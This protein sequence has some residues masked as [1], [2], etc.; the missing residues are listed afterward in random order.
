[1]PCKQNKLRVNAEGR[2]Y[3][4]S[5]RQI[6]SW[7]NFKRAALSGAV[8][9]ILEPPPGAGALLEWVSPLKS[10]SYRQY[11]DNDFL[12]V[13]GLSVSATELKRF[14]PQNG[15]CW[16]A[17]ALLRT[18]D[19]I[20]GVVLVDAKS[21]PKET[22]SSCCKAISMNRI[23]IESSLLQTKKWLRVRADA[24]WTGSLYWYANRLAHLFFLR[25]QLGLNAWLVNIYFLSD[26]QSPAS[27]DEWI[28]SIGKLKDDVGLPLQI[29]PYCV[30][31]L[32]DCWSE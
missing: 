25:E 30:D 12:R 28:A 1:M 15:P 20:P 11:N 23:T 31:L 32:L 22:R 8:L 9:N 4:G 26:P 27:R 18:G 10:E 17:L 5:Q 29:V 7:V 21:H 16:D 2:A 19:E 3:A 14:W 24:S 6:Q 13:L